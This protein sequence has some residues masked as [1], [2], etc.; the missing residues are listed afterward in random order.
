M[1]F[2]I[3]LLIAFDVTAALLPSTQPF[4]TYTIL[5]GIC[6]LGGLPHELLARKIGSITGAQAS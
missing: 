5:N 3:I 2:M 6:I 4:W 1:K